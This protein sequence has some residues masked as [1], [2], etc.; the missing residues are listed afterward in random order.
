MDL[1]GKPG[2]E[3]GDCSSGSS[4]GE[5]MERRGLIGGVCRK[6]KK[7]HLLV[8]STEGK[9]IQAETE[10]LVGP[11]DM[12]KGVGREGWAESMVICLGRLSQG[13]GDSSQ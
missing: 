6:S 11:R 5:R 3:L 10:T 1:G 12:Q 4:W 2:D 7:M 9:K 8:G 13:S